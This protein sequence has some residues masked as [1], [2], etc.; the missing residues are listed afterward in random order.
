MSSRAL[1]RDSALLRLRINMVV[2]SRFRG[3]DMSGIGEGVT[4]SES[5]GVAVEV[6]AVVGEGVEMVDGN[7]FLSLAFNLAF[8][9]LSFISLFTSWFNTCWTLLLSSKLVPSSLLSLLLLNLCKN[10][11]LFPL[12]PSSSSEREGTSVDI[13]SFLVE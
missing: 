10:L 1:I 4:I 6:A 5:V 9:S 3:W 8:S 11:S 12:I 7:L 13:L 2:M